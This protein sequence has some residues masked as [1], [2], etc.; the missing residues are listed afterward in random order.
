MPLHNE[1]HWS[2]YVRRSGRYGSFEEF[3]LFVGR[4]VLTNLKLILY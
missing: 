3:N 2:R 4:Y 1:D